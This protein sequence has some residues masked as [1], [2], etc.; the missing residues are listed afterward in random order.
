VIRHNM[1]LVE[2]IDIESVAEAMSSGWIAQGPRVERVEEDFT[3]YMGQGS[4]C[5]CSSGTAALFLSLR[6]L[7]IEPGKRVAVPTYAC[8][9]LLNA[10][11]MAGGE[12]VVCDVELD[13][14]NLA[15]ATMPVTDCAVAVHTFGAPADV[16][17]IA[18]KTKVVIEDC[19]QSLGG[20][21]NGLP[22]GGTGDAAVFSFYATKVISCGHGGLVWDKS[23]AVSEW[24]SDYRNFDCQ[25]YYKPRFNFHMSDIQA[26]MVHSQFQRLEDIASRRRAIASKY[27]ETMDGKVLVQAGAADP[28]RMMYRFVLVFNE[29][30]S[31][32]SMQTFLADAGI[33]T[34]VPIE[35]HEL[36]HRYLGLDPTKFP[37]A[38]RLVDT[39][40]SLPVYPAL[41]DDEVDMICRILFKGVK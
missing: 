8:S 41:T 15:A 29:R 25:E 11:N 14:F 7:G 5:A 17:A 27:L 21:S 1:P 13:S 12:P 35:R 36:L 32:D 22:L 40:L 4:A 39:T 2:T 10:V 34:V 16:A 9:A 20:T 38:E 24:A 6:G 30:K 26:A 31:R 33:Q 23:G 28:G 37:N 3:K 18:R 19:C